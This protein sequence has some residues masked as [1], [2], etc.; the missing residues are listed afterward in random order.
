MSGIPAEIV[1]LALLA[2]TLGFAVLRPRGLPEAVLAV[3]AAALVLGLGMLSAAEVRSEVR[4]LAPTVAFLAAVLVLAELADREGLFAALGAWIALASRG[5]PVRLL[6]LVFAIA[7]AVTAVLSLD[8][9]VVLFTPVVFRTVTRLRLRSK[10]QVYACTHMANSASL[11][12]PVSNLTNLLAFKASGLSFARFG[13]IMALPWVVAIAAE[14]L[15]LRRFFASDLVGRG[16][17]PDERAEVPRFALVVIALTL[18]GFFATSVAGIS[19]AYAALGGALVLGLPALARRRVSVREVGA[20][21]DLPFLAFVFALGVV[22][23]AVSE[24]GLQSAL[25]RIVPG[26]AS[27]PAL[28]AIAFLAAVIAKVVNNLP[29]VLLLLPAVAG[30]GAGPVLALLIGVNVGPNLAYVGS[31]ATLLWRRILQHHGADPSAVEFLR[32][33]AITVPLA[34]AAAT[35]ALWISLQVVA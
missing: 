8:A 3:P 27:L 33:G 16:S 6:A 20:A 2:A 31:L 28:L 23:A 29:A 26:G 13:A 24:H 18:A 32:L 22:V 15:V 1:S 21:L 10:P 17:V 35:I 4:G 11:L 34:I 14:W 5:G 9:T 25:E 30:S 19:P 12:L 7:A